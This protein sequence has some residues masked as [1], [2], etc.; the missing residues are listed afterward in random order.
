MVCWRPTFCAACVCTRYLHVRTLY[1]KCRLSVHPH[2][3][4][5]PSPRCAAYVETSVAD[6]HSHDVFCLQTSLA[7]RLVTREGSVAPLPLYTSPSLPNITLGLPATGPA[8]VSWSPGFCLTWG[9]CLPQSPQ[10][11]EY[12]GFTFQGAAGQQDA[13]RLALPALQQRISLFPGTHLTPYLST[14]PLERDGGAA[15]SPLLQHMVLLE[16]APTQTPLVTGKNHSQVSGSYLG[17]CS[18]ASCSS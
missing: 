1:C 13:E 6:S 8:A 4:R 15:H 14:S 11:E 9:G 18:L 17:S 10:S 12:P 2:L 3:P 5:L 7:H 16:Q